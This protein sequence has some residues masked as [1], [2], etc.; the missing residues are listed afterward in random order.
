M[1]RRNLSASHEM[2][3]RLPDFHGVYVQ[4]SIFRQLRAEIGSSSTEVVYGR[5]P[6]FEIVSI[7]TFGCSTL[8]L[9][10]LLFLDG[11]MQT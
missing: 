10:I 3:P 8:R 6:K 9:S 5:V 2:F 11:K 1:F 7:K 4:N